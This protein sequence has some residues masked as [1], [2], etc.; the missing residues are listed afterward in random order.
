MFGDA[1]DCEWILFALVLHLRSKVVGEG[2]A[3]A[4]VPFV[5]TTKAKPMKERLNILTLPAGQKAEASI[6]SLWVFSHSLGE[7]PWKAVGGLY[8]C[9]Q[10]V[11]PE[12]SR[13][14]PSMESLSGS[15]TGI[16]PEV[17]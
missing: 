17:V 8:G 5:E 11:V 14:F 4:S 2:H 7:S 10:E 3:H 16:L 9:F 1:C 13:C 15:C 12:L 6:D